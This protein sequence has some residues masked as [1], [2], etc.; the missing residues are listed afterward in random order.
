MSTGRI[1]GVVATI[2]KN[3]E[4]AEKKYQALVAEAAS[5]EDS[6]A[7]MK[8]V[9][10][11]LKTLFPDSDTKPARTRKPG[12][13]SRRKATASPVD[14]E[15]VLKTIADAGATGAKRSSV[16]RILESRT[17]KTPDMAALGGVLKTLQEEGRISR[18]GY[19][20]VI[21]APRDETPDSSTQEIPVEEVPAAPARR[22]RPRNP[23]SEKT[24]RAM[25]AV[26]DV[27]QAAGADGYKSS[28]IRTAV[29][30]ATGIPLSSAHTT[31]AIKDLLADGRVRREGY[32]YF[33]T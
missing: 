7:N 17:G 29:E 16:A 20:Y 18:A 6:I 4:T 13:Q 28:A 8:R 10:E 15:T 31:R 9:A 5:L 1:S 19:H 26:F 33:A 24:A 14:A 11:D 22:G 32:R 12:R 3:I 30:E 21:D 25:A 23:V 27:V 2:S